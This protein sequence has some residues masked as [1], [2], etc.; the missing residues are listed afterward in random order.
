MLRDPKYKDLKSVSA[1]PSVGTKDG[2]GTKKET[3]MK[4]AALK[5]NRLNFE[6]SI[7]P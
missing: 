2:E 3:N 7:N 4:K 1:G 6:A 5:D